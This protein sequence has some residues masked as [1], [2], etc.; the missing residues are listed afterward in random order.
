MRAATGLGRVAGAM[1]RT[2]RR[3]DGFVIGGRVV[4][5]ACPDAFAR[6]CSGRRVAFVSATNGKTTTT[7]LLAAAMRAAGP[8]LTNNSGANMP[9][10]LVA[11]LAM[12]TQRAPDDAPVVLEADETFLPGL[13]R[14]TP[15]ALLVL[16]N[17]SRDQLDRLS[18]VAMVARRWRTTFAAMPGL[19]AVANADDPHIVWAASALAD[20]T[21]VSVGNTWTADSVLCPSCGAILRRDERDWSCECGF[22]RPSPS[23]VLD[24]GTVVDPAGARHGL[25]LRLPGRANEANAVMALA[26]AHALGVPPETAL[27]AMASVESVGGRYQTVT[28]GG[29]HVRLLLGKNPA[30]WAEMFGMLAPPPAPVVIAINARAA[31]GKDPSWLWD[32][33]FENLAGRLVVATGERRHDLAVRLTYAGVEHV[34]VEDPWTAMPAAVGASDEPLDAVGTYTAFREMLRRGGGARDAG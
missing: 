10:G 3:G 9:A 27:P 25:A 31:D 22:R 5:A 29:R 24:D 32:V 20:V 12:P 14:G 11:A 7:K 21:W 34:T 4:L 33:P 8:V 2:L 30:G 23:W 6:L 18:E 26:A 16:G 28:L 1:S 17:L 15:E 19:T 13:L